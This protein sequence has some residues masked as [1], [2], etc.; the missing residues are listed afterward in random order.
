[1]LPKTAHDITASIFHNADE[2]LILIY[3]HNQKLISGESFTAKLAKP[4]S[5]RVDMTPYYYRTPNEDRPEILG[6]LMF[7]VQQYEE[8]DR[9]VSSCSSSGFSGGGFGYVVE[10][11]LFNHLGYDE[12]FTFDFAGIPDNQQLLRFEGLFDQC[13]SAAITFKNKRSASA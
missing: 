5:I 12:S 11:R 2:K 6:L 4:A 8:Q 10:F 7:A 1:M 3:N 9:S 13:A